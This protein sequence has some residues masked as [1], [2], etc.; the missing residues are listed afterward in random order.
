MAALLEEI[1]HNAES[2]TDPRAVPGT[3][4][5]R[6]PDVVLLDIGMPYVDG[7]EVA[8]QLKSEFARLCLVAV[9]G[10][11]SDEHR[12]RGL[13]AGFEAYLAKPVDVTILQS[14]LA[15]IFALRKASPL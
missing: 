6:R 3:V 7:F 4:R 8:R 12:K 13:E 1:G 2:I 14:T 5:R 9:T 10:R 15:T 11:A